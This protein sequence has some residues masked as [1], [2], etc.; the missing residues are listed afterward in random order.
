MHRSV[1]RITQIHVCESAARACCL[2]PNHRNRP[3]SHLQT[4]RANRRRSPLHLI[5]PLH[6]LHLLPRIHPQEGVTTA[7]A[8][9]EVALRVL[10]PS[11]ARVQQTQVVLR[12]VPQLTALMVQGLL[13]GVPKREVRASIGA[14]SP[15]TCSGSMRKEKILTKRG[16]RECMLS[17]YVLDSR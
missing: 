1:P 8:V 7:V 5:R 17:G 10:V 13:F 11:N 12:V 16:E 3:R 6:Q 15:N 2:H 4:R 9:M 14:A